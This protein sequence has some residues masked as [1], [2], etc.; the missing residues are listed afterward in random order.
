[1][2]NQS[3]QLLARGAPAAGLDSP[4]AATAEHHNLAAAMVEPVPGVL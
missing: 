4:L 2:A 3:G 1:V